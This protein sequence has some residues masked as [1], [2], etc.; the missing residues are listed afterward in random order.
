MSDRNFI[1]RFRDQMTPFY[2]HPKCCNDVFEISKR[3]RLLRYVVEERPL[4]AENMSKN[5]HHIF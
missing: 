5:V 2:A 3:D 1:Y 4:K